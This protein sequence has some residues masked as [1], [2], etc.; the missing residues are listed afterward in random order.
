MR[1]EI[2]FSVDKTKRYK[3]MY[4]WDASK[5]KVLFIMFNPSSATLTKQVSL[6]GKRII[7]WAERNDFGGVWIGNLFPYISSNAIEVEVESEDERLINERYLL[8]MKKECTHV[9]FAWGAWELTSLRTK[10]I[11]E[12]FPEGRAMGTNT[13]GSPAHPLS[14]NFKLYGKV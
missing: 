13:D 6:T 2:Y 10:R 1:R 11:K 3:L 9:I 5:P 7:G 8:E 4:E 12:L 14:N